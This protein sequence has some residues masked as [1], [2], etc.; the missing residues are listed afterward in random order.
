MGTKSRR[1]EGFADQGG[2]GLYRPSARRTKGFGTRR[3]SAPKRPNVA[4]A[5]LCR[6]ADKWGIELS[7]RGY[8]DYAVIDGGEI[9]GFIEV[10]PARSSHLKIAQAA[11]QRLCERSGIPF[12]RWDPFKGLPPFFWKAKTRFK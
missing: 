9:V 1:Y 2:Q 8:P 11:F 3:R 12:C 10:K 7:R 6:I 4:E 5:E